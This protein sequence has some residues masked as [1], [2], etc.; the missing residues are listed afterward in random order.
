MS[1][2]PSVAALDRSVLPDTAVVAADGRLSVG[3]CDV[4]ELAGRFGTP[5]FVYDEA[6]LVARCAEARRSFDDGVAYATKAF[7]CRAMARLAHAEGLCL[8]VAS[9]GELHCALSAGVPAGRLV[10]HGN[11]KSDAELAL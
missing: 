8:D 3:G 5:L 2:M 7:L 11:Y 10:L 9:E 4:V 6:H 1:A